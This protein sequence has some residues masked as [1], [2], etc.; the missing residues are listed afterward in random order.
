MSNAWTIEQFSTCVF[1]THVHAIFRMIDTEASPFRWFVICH[2]MWRKLTNWARIVCSQVH[3]RVHN[4]IN[5][6]MWIIGVTAFTYDSRRFHIAFVESFIA[7]VLRQTHRTFVNVI[8]VVRNFCMHRIGVIRLGCVPFARRK[9]KIQA[10]SWTQK[11][12]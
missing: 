10:K 7:I 6:G 8:G 3:P 2:K 5:L 1:G 9:T 11:K 4:L 12:R